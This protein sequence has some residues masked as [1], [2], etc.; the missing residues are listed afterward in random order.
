MPLEI[1]QVILLSDLVIHRGASLVSALSL[2]IKIQPQTHHG[3][4]GPLAERTPR[5]HFLVKRSAKRTELGIGEPYEQGFTGAHR[6]SPS[7]GVTYIPWALPSRFQH[8]ILHALHA[9]FGVVRIRPHEVLFS[10]PDAIRVLLI[11]VRRTVEGHPRPGFSR[12]PS[13]T[14]KGGN[15]KCIR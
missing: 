15:P 9:A 5:K 4:T 3:I 11:Q 14:Q 7:F 2:D 10:G 6:R 12:L 1:L 13:G 8:H